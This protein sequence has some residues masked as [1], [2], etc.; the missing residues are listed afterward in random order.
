MADNDPTPH[1]R[2][3]GISAEDFRAFLDMKGW[4]DRQVTIEVGL[5]SRKTL[6]KYKLEGAPSTSPMPLSPRGLAPW[7]G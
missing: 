6:T 1:Q 3:A 7:P 5:G 4:S 2:Q